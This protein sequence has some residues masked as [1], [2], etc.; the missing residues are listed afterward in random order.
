M[1]SVTAFYIP[2]SVFFHQTDTR[3]TT[4]TRQQQV[5]NRL[6]VSPIF[7]NLCHYLAIHKVSFADLWDNSLISKWET[8]HGSECITTVI[9]AVQQERKPP[10]PKEIRPI[11]GSPAHRIFIHKDAEGLDS[12]IAG[13]LDKAE[14]PVDLMFGF[15]VCVSVIWARVIVLLSFTCQFINYNFY[16]F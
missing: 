7:C 1:W 12:P 16:F 9:S 13:F 10:E 3:M 8:E 5:G 2:V 15:L 11:L 4:M 6:V 14:V